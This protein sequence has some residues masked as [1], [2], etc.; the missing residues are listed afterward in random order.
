LRY[1]NQIIDI[2]FKVFQKTFIFEESGGESSWVDGYFYQK[3]GEYLI[4]PSG[5]KRVFLE[6]KDSF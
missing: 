5:I 2:G 6:K 3:W 1:L 4:Q